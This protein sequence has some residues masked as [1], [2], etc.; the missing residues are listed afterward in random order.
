[1]TKETRFELQRDLVCNTD[2]S[3]RNPAKESTNTL[4]VEVRKMKDLNEALESYFEVRLLL[5]YELTLT[6]REDTRLQ[7]PT[8]W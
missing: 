6:G 8:L 4:S 2:K 5:T 1:M 3:H 7:M